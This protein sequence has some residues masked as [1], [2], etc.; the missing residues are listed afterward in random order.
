MIS[1]L[2]LKSNPEE[3]KLQSLT[4]L[5]RSL[6]DLIQFFRRK[7]GCYVSQ[8]TMGRILG[9]SR[10]TINREIAKLVAL[11]LLEIKHRYNNSNVTTLSGFFSLPHVKKIL[12]K[13]FSNFEETSPDM[14]K[15]RGVCLTSNVSFS[16]P[17]ILPSEG[18]PLQGG[19]ETEDYNEKSLEEDEAVSQPTSIPQSN[20]D[21]ATQVK[22]ICVALQRRGSTVTNDDA[23]K[24]LAYS[25]DVHDRASKRFKANAFT[26]KDPLAYYLFICKEIVSQDGRRADWQKV[27][28]LR[29]DGFVLLEE[30]LQGSTRSTTGASTAGPQKRDGGGQSYSEHVKQEQRRMA[31]E[32][33]ARKTKSGS[34]AEEVLGWHHVVVELQRRVAEGDIGARFTLP[35]AE[36]KLK[37]LISQYQGNTD[38]SVVKKNMT[39][40]DSVSNFKTPASILSSSSA[41][42]LKKVESATLKD[43]PAEDIWAE[44]QDYDPML[45]S[46]EYV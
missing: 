29:E 10:R 3:Q 39:I 17:S 25:P 45:E 40:I 23:L 30:T 44:W 20:T 4:Y 42:C 41:T 19:G 28:G 1:Q 36:S 21:E 5:Q 37:Y 6:I 46:E 26:I 34:L 11:G 8:A 38:P 32:A 18:V 16:Y 15:V 13:Y 9:Y 12:S 2:T 14:G 35:H 31:D 43:E 24:L 7:K 22:K 27:N 33:S